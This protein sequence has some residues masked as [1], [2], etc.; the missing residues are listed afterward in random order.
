MAK[1]RPFGK[2]D[3]LSKK[4]IKIPEQISQRTKNEPKTV[5]K[6]SKFCLLSTKIR[7]HLVIVA[8]RGPVRKDVGILS[9]PAPQRLNNTNRAIFLTYSATQ[10]L[11]PKPSCT[12]SGAKIHHVQNMRGKTNGNHTSI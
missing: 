7:R 10:A 12:I 6:P 1:L 9:P 5:P 3:H 4:G 8:S 11:N 2:P